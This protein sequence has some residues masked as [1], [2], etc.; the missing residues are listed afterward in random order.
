MKDKDR[1]IQTA[2]IIKD[3]YKILLRNDWFAL[4]ALLWKPI[5]SISYTYIE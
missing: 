4:L 5:E 1:N 3:S 2:K